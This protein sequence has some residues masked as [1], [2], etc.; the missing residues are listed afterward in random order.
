MLEKLRKMPKFMK[1]EE[2]KEGM[3][4]A[5]P[6]FNRYGQ[7][8]LPKDSVIEEKHKS[9]LKIWGV[10]CVQICAG[11]NDKINESKLDELYALAGEKLGK[12]LLWTPRNEIENDLYEAALM[13]IAYDIA[14]NE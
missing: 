4:L 11:E 12:R 13:K 6:V 10:R 8:L 14:V 9:L 2:I 3:I 7:I 5:S 1:I